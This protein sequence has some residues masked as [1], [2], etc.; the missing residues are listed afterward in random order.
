MT[1]SLEPD[2]AGS[3]RVT[4]VAAGSVTVTVDS[5]AAAAIDLANS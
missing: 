1:L 5:D 3:V 2:A 4:V